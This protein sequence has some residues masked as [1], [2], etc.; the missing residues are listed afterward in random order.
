MIEIQLMLML[1]RRNSKSNSKIS[2][3]CSHEP[4]LL[5]NPPKENYLILE[6][7]WLI[8]VLYEPFLPPV[9]IS[10]PPD[11]LPTG[12]ATTSAKRSSRLESTGRTCDKLCANTF[13][14]LPGCL[15]VLFLRIKA[16]QYPLTA[17]YSSP[18]NAGQGRKEN[19]NA[20]Q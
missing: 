6:N 11:C 18:K 3:N 15:D 20:T 8:A 4:E 12:K 5:L 14:G 16:K 9:F 13:Q 7:A 17:P 1:N 2:R 10:I 19:T